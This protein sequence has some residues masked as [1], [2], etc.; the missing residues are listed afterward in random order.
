[1]VILFPITLLSLSHFLR[2]TRKPVRGHGFEKILVWYHN[3]IFDLYLNN[4]ECIV[5]F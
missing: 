5:E 2:S 3:H 1:M 4:S